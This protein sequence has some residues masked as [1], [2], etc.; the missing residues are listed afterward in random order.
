MRHKLRRAV[1]SSAFSCSNRLPEVLGVPVD[2]D[3]G[4]QVQPGRAVVL[5]FE[6][7]ITDFT[8][9]NDAQGVFEGVMGLALVETDLR[10]AGCIVDLEKQIGNGHSRQTVIE[11]E[12]RSLGCLWPG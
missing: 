1:K 2:D 6:G 11:I 9:A 12:N 5:T 8:L 3:G 7:P 4:Q 10:E